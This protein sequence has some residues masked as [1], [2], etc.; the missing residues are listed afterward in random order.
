MVAA[1]LAGRK[2]ALFFHP[3]SKKFGDLFFMPPGFGKKTWSVAGFWLV[4][5]ICA[6]CL[7]KKPPSKFCQVISLW[8]D[9]SS[10]SQALAE[11]GQLKKSSLALFQSHGSPWAPLRFAPGSPHVKLSVAV[12]GAWVLLGS[13]PGRKVPPPRALMVPGSSSLSPG[14]ARG[15]AEGAGG[16]REGRCGLEWD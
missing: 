6:A 13:H 14:A 16:G 11:A 1:H 15:K 10:C 9:K 3:C 4:C 5:Q 8:R 7:Q 2:Y 12:L